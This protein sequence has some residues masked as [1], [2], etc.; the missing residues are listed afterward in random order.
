MEDVNEDCESDEIEERELLKKLESSVRKRKGTKVDGL[1][2]SS[3]SALK[4]AE[5]EKSEG[6]DPPAEAGGKSEHAKAR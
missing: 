4:R 1:K 3:E 5:S 6:D 2:P